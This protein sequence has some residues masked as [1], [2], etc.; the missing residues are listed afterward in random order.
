MAETVA[1]QAVE[2]I[3]QIGIFDILVPFLLG[4]GALY[5]MLEKSQVF[6][7]DRHDVNALISI[8]VGII[9]ALSWSARNFILNFIPLVIILAFFMFIMVL[10]AQWLG[11]E[12]KFF[13]N[14]MNQPAIIIPVVL[15]VLVLIMVAQSGGLDFIMGRANYTGDIGIPTEDLTPQDLANPAIVLAQPQIAGTLIVLAVF[16]VV[17]YMVTQKK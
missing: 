15:I 5:G 16:A 8:A 3:N 7:K 2:I 13:I 10:L 4:A 12:P 1:S 6:G 9:I 14:I 17:T 11:L